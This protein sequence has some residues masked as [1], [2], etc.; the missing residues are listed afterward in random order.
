MAAVLKCAYLLI[1]MAARVNTGT[2]EK[3]GPKLKLRA[4]E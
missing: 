3:R 1:E 2:V 4:C